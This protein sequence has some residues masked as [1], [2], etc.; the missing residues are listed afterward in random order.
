MLC[1]SLVLLSRFVQL[2]CDVAQDAIAKA[3][4]AFWNAM[5]E[6]DPKKPIAHSKSLV[7]GTQVI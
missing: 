6:M 3:E 4:D 2:W 5:N 7:I 1:L